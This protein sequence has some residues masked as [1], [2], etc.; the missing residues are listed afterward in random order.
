MLVIFKVTC[1]C[2]RIRT[3]KTMEKAGC[4]EMNNG[5]AFA[6]PEH[7]V[8]EARFICN[9]VIYQ[10]LDTPSLSVVFLGHLLCAGHSWKLES[11]RGTDNKDNCSP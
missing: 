3:P 6:T 9:T 11:S 8:G 5:A 2:E 4:K 10:D 7:M 1:T